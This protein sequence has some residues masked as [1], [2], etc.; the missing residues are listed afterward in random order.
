M[1]NTAILT[2]EPE[3]SAERLAKTCFFFIVIDIF[4]TIILFSFCFSGIASYLLIFWLIFQ[5]IRLVSLM[6]QSIFGI[7]LHLFASLLYTS[8]V[9]VVV[10]LYECGV[11]RKC[12]HT[13]CKTVQKSLADTYDKTTLIFYAAYVFLIQSIILLISSELLQNLV[14]KK[15]FTK[16][17]VQM[18]VA[19]KRR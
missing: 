1:A 8:G 11:I 17:N 10:T 2:Y 9:G 15:E 14:V 12:F 16:I 3:N 4:L 18:A 6:N 7:I 19:S 13:L 5:S